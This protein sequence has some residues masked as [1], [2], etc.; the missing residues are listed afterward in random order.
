ML[1]SLF[2]FTFSLRLSRGAGSDRPCLCG[3]WAVCLINCW[4]SCVRWWKRGAS[5]WLRAPRGNVISG[6]LWLAQNRHILSPVHFSSVSLSFQC[7]CPATALLSLCPLLSAVPFPSCPPLCPSPVIFGCLIS[8]FLVRCARDTGGKQMGH[9]P[10]EKKKASGGRGRCLGRV[11]AYHLFSPWIMFSGSVLSCRSP[12]RGSV[13]P[14]WAG[15]GQRGSVSVQLPDASCPHLFAAFTVDTDE[16]PMGVTDQH[17]YTC[18]QSQR[19]SRRSY[20]Q[21]CHGNRLSCVW[22]PLWYSIYKW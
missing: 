1:S 12:S 22:T 7:S 8:S 2:D 6:F 10:E 9:T 16:T 14:L 4:V 3:Y 19:E 13:T 5:V 21:G 17:T 11:S 15:K 18:T 20:R